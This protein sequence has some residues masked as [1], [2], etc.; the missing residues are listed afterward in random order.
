MRVLPAN[1]T[2]APPARFTSE[3]IELLAKMEHGRWN[4]ER[5]LDGWRLGARNPEK[6]LTPF[7]VTW[8]ELDSVDP[9]ARK[10]D[11]DIVAAIPEH[12]ESLGLVVHRIGD[13]T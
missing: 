1:Q 12:L 7:L 3:E 2:Q 6:K 11:R 13:T 10:W 5:A 9:Q 8:D 4:V